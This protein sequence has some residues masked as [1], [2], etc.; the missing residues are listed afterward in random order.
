MGVAKSGTT[1]LHS[2]LAAHPQVFMSTPKEPHFLAS[3]MATPAAAYALNTVHDETSY[4]ALF[5][6]ATEPIRGEASTSNWWWPRMARRIDSF[7]PG[8]RVI[9]VLRDPVDRAFSHYLN[10]LRDQHEVRP[11]KDTLVDERPGEAA[12]RWGDPLI[13]IELGFYADRLRGFREV[14]GERLLP[15]VYEELF[16]SG[17]DPLAEIAPFLGID[18]TPPRDTAPGS[19]ARN[20]H[21]MAKGGVA[22]A[23]LRSRAV[24]QVARRVLPAGARA[25]GYE[26]MLRSAP[27]PQLDPISAS[28]LADLYRRDAAETEELFGGPLPWLGKGATPTAGDRS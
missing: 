24:R 2:L 23:I 22:Q 20:S 14:F 8:A 16:A 7:S 5:A 26:A 10:D 4:L 12:M 25:R 19:A 15:L 17:H 9:V 28:R 13:R 6:N 21:R 27:R 11:F 3:P 1:N 18:P